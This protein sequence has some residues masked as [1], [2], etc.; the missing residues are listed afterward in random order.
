MLNEKSFNAAIK[1]IK[2]TS[3]EFA[4]T[5]HE[6]GIFAISQ[7]NEH[8]NVGFGVRLIEAM[9]KKHDRSRVVSWLVKFGKFGVTKGELV[10][11]SRKDITPA[12]LDAML[13]QAEAVPYW[14]LTA[15]RKLVE[16][17]NYLAMLKS[18]VAK[19]KL[20]QEKQ[21]AGKQVDELH[22]DVLAK[23]EKVLES[24]KQPVAPAAEAV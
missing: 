17:V 5:I 3:E 24:C 6:A 21:A 8:G 23:L 1:R 20:A 14:E 12:N 18:I 13:A 2:T 19:H 11:R 22:L 4:Q 9:G 15:E 16:T 7:A 10:Y